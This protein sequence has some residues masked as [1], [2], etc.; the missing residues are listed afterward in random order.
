MQS[1]GM[2]TKG[3]CF[4]TTVDCGPSRLSSTSDKWFSG[5]PKNQPIH[6][7]FPHPASFERR[8]LNNSDLGQLR[9]DKSRSLLPCGRTQRHPEDLGPLGTLGVVSCLCT[10]AFLF[11]I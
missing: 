3:R 11:R 10:S 5:T 9:R 8:S 2:K 1:L 7:L 6:F 4:S